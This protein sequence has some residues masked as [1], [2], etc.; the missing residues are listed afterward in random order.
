MVTIPTTSGADGPVNID[1]TNTTTTAH[2]PGRNHAQFFKVRAM[3]VGD[4][5]SVTKD[6]LL[7]FK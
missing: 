1:D 2:E 3:A 7:V 6:G 4:G 5:H